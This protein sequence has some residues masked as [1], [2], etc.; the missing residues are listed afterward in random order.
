MLFVSIAYVQKPLLGVSSGHKD[1]NFDPSLCLHPY[2]M[3]ASSEGNA[4]RTCTK[5]SCT[6]PYYLLTCM[7]I[8]KSNFRTCPQFHLHSIA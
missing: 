5:T 6:G 4:I 7:F 2:L 8:H 1:L 3:H